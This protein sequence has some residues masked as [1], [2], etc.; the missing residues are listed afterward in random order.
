M[1]IPGFIEYEPKLIAITIEGNAEILQLV[2]HNAPHYY[3]RIVTIKKLSNMGIRTVVRMDP[4]LIHL[5][6]ALYKKDW[7]GQ[8]SHII[9]TLGASGVRHVIGGTGRLSKRGDKNDS[10]KNNS[11]WKRVLDLISGYSAAA[12][13]RFQ[14]DYVF[15]SDWAGRGY[16]LRRDLRIDFHRKIKTLVEAEGMTYATCQELPAKECD[17]DGIPHCEGMPLPFSMKGLG[18]KYYPIPGCTANC[19]VSCREL[20]NPPCAKQALITYKPL[21]KS[22]LY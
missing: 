17:S 1:E 19:F 4:L 12:A 16:M 7:F 3:A 20:I 10:D 22:Y 9:T 21:R 5:F 2:S 6:Q 8:I 11:S 13:R 14:E 18:D 15:E